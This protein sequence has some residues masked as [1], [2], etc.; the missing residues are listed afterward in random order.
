M[1]ENKELTEKEL[2]EISGG[3]KDESWDLVW[4][5]AAG[6]YGAFITKD[7]DSNP[8]GSLIDYKGMTEFFAKRGYKFI[9]GY[10]DEPTTIINPEGIPVGVD[11]A[12]YMLRNKQL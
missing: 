9:P 11:Y 4:A 1:I 2:I 10:G 7:A 12:V 6:G 3:S 8:D 5:L